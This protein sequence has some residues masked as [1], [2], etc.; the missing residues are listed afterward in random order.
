VVSWHLHSVQ[1]LSYITLPEWQKQGLTVAITTRTG[2]FSQGEYSSLNLAFHVGDDQTAVL[3]N[4]ELLASVL[5][6]S[7]ADMVCACQVHKANVRIVT[8]ADKGKGV[9]EY[10]SALPE[11]D[12]MV[13]DCE[14]VFLTTFYADCIP[15]LLFDV[16]RRVIGLAHGGW[17]G[18]MAKIASATVE[19]MR[20]EFGS[21]PQDIKAFIG[22]GIGGCCY[23]VDDGLAAQ[24][25]T[26]FGKD[27]RFLLE[28]KQGRNYWYLDRTNFFI[29][30][31]AGLH[32]Q[33]IGL[34]GMCTRCN[35]E[36]F[37][38]YRGSGGRTGRFAVVLGFNKR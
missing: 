23:E 28:E 34:C 12:A 6:I 4:R 7:L 13:T 10:A 37:Y 8:E 9:F 36:L 32:H 15:I 16:T 17:K 27:S 31:N 22:P 20:K 38:S 11:T 35:Q 24:V 18:T 5:R 26:V 19:V 33:N 29:L 14:G 25:R 3:S 30:E 2:G 1:G 21:Y